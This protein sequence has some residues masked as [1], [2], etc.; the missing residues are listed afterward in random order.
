MFLVFLLNQ[1]TVDQRQHLLNLREESKMKRS[2]VSLVVIAMCVLSAGAA[3]N[4]QENPGVA[5]GASMV[6]KG[7]VLAVDKV[8]RI[9]TV[10]GSEGNE[11]DIPVGEEAHNFDQI[12]VGDELTIEAFESVA[13]FVGN[14]DTQADAAAG[15]AI[16]RSE[17]GEKPAGLAVAAAEVS[18]LVV[19]IDREARMLTLKLPAGD[20]VTTHVD[21][22]VQAFDT[23]TVGDT[24]HA[25][26]TRA[27]AVSVVTP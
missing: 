19:A 20:E 26:L 6:A 27:I 21:E 3:V 17:K 9:V 4:A 25:R 15:M 10:R 1:G 12:A 18:A 22:T 23:L 14:P 11:V 16:T 24:I 2:Y 13:L 8:N 7:T 5:V